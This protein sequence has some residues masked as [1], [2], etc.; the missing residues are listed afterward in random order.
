[1]FDNNRNLKHYYIGLVT[2]VLVGLLLAIPIVAS[3]LL[4]SSSYDPCLISGANH[5][6]CPEPED[7][8]CPDGYQQN[9]DEECVPDHD[10]CPKGTHSKDDDESGRCHRDGSSER[11]N[12]H[13]DRR[14]R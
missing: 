6:N 14:R 4:A 9:E 1:L 2:G 10:E 7:G 3:T 11:M 12:E 8:Q 5:R 13:N